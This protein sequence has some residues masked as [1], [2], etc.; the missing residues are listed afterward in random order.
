ME[1]SII[2]CIVVLGGISLTAIICQV[3]EECQER[4]MYIPVM[5][6]V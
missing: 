2:I 4:P 3:S 5:N 1:I 6:E